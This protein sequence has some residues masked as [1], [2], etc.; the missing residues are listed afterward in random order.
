[1]IRKAR[2]R[3]AGMAADSRFT[4]RFF[5]PALALVATLAFASSFDSSGPDGPDLPHFDK[6]AHF[7]VYGLMGTLWFRWIKGDLRSVLRFVAAVALSLSFG[8]VDEWIQSHNPQRTTDLLDWV[9]DSLGALTGIFVYRNWTLY[10]R[11]L[12]SPIGSL[13]R[14]RIVEMN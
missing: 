11:I 7:F 13:L 3:F 6:I 14:G 5:W 4:L 10:R 12:E 8:V 1:M 9:A 2:L